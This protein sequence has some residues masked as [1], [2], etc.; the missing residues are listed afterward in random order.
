MSRLGECILLISFPERKRRTR[1]LSQR[2]HSEL[3]CFFRTASDELIPAL[4]AFFRGQVFLF[5][6]RKLNFSIVGQFLIEPPVEVG[7][8]GPVGLDSFPFLREPLQK[9]A[10]IRIVFG[11]LVIPVEGERAGSPFRIRRPLHIDMESDAGF[12]VEF[13]QGFQYIGEGFQPDLL[14]FI[15]H[16]FCGRNM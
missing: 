13:V 5:F 10:Q 11:C 3:L 4:Q 9:E 7:L 6:I 15:A 1:D 12:L 16:Q 14:P 8:I 2:I